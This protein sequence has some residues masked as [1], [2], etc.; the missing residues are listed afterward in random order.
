MQNHEAGAIRGCTLQGRRQTLS[1]SDQLYSAACTIGTVQHVFFPPFLILAGMCQ[2]RAKLGS[3]LK[4]NR[5]FSVF[6]T[7][8]F[9]PNW[10]CNTLELAGQSCAKLGVQFWELVVSLTPLPL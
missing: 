10:E 2:P 5:D 7:V 6:I 9:V 1:C 4:P 8:L 3:L